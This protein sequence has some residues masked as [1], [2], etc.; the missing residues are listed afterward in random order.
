MEELRRLFLTIRI[1]FNNCEANNLFTKTFRRKLKAMF[2][3]HKVATTL[4]DCLIRSV[5]NHYS[6]IIIFDINQYGRPT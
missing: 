4:A 3:L 2:M 1:V 5:P 6:Q